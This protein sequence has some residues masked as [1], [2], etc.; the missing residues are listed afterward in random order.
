MATSAGTEQY[1]QDTSSGQAADIEPSSS[2]AAL[3]QQA[4]AD[5]RVAAAADRRVAA[6]ADRR[7]ADCELVYSELPGQCQT[8][9]DRLEADQE[10]VLHVLQ[11]REAVH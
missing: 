6:A 7:V 10:L 1:T 5:R 9:A 2:L 11:G 3:W 8:F 4:A